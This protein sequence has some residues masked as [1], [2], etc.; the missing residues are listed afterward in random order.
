VQVGQ[1]AVNYGT[2]KPEV[3]VEH[4]KFISN[5]ITAGKGKHII[6]DDAPDNLI[7]NNILREP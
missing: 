4:N 3:I 5:T 6:I 1:D 2:A 7:E